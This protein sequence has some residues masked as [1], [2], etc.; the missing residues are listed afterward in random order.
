MN[1]HEVVVRIIQPA[2]QPQAKKVTLAEAP[3]EPAGKALLRRVLNWLV[4]VALF[5]LGSYAVFSL[6]AF[7]LAVR[8]VMVL[9]G[10][11]LSIGLVATYAI[12]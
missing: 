5:T 8:D 3:A 9:V 11:P 7:G 1:A 6:M 12:V 2:E 10:I 4:I